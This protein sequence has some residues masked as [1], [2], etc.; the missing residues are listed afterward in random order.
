[1]LGLSYPFMKPMAINSVVRSDKGLIRQNNEDSVGI[2][3]DEGLVVLADGM[4]GHSGGEVAS[5]LAIE[6]I[7]R[8]IS[9]DHNISPATAIE[10]ANKAILKRSDDDARLRGM[11]TTVV[12]GRFRD[13]MIDYAHVG[14]SRLYLWRDAKLSQLT[15]DH[16]MI[17][18]MVDEGLYSSL[19]EARRDGVRNNL[20][21][22]GVGLGRQLEV[23]SGGL[24]LCPSDL[25]LFCSDGLSNML[26]DV[27]IG[28]TLARYAGRMEEAVDRLLG[29]ALRRGGYDN[30]SLA[31]VEPESM[32]Y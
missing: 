7:V 16:S 32:T 5:T 21:T 25:F 13:G 27:L 20:L 10:Y 2:L 3:A 6:S 30:I 24:Q 15:R 23:D 19:E 29:L 31:L 26:S 8:L 18:E 9:I 1:M 17:Q 4:G 12:V 22:R 28:Q 14:D 11:A